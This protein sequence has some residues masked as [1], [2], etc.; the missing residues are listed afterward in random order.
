MNQ[1]EGINGE[2][3]W[4]VVTGQ[5]W[6]VTIIRDDKTFSAPWSMERHTESSEYVLRCSNHDS[7]KITPASSLSRVETLPDPLF[8]FRFLEEFCLSE[9]V[10]KECA[11]MALAVVLMFPKYKS[12]PIRIP[13]LISPE[14]IHCSSSV[15]KKYY[16]RLSECLSQCITLSCCEEGIA[17][18]IM[19]CIVR[20]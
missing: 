11:A 9:G 3:F 12:G 2:N 10:K 8:A 13:P 4:E 5:Q 14:E 15:E 16:K 7:P 17:S 19:Q 18:I 20:V 1:S 6:Q